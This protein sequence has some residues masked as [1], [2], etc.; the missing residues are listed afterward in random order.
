MD[1]LFTGRHIITLSE[2]PSTNTYAMQLLKEKDL[3]EGTL[4]MTGNQTGGRGQHGNSWEAERGKNLT[5]SL[6]MHPV[7]MTANEQFYLS[8]ITALAVLGTLTE[9]LPAS[10]YD[11]Q[12]KWP[13]DVLVQGEKIAGVLIENVVVGA[14]LQ[15]SVIGVGLNVNQER[16]GK[17]PRAATS[18]KKLLQ[19]DVEL[20]FVL[21]RFCKHFEALY[22]SLRQ[23][24]NALI[25]K[26]YISN[27]YR[28]NQRALYRAAGKEFAA[29]ICGVSKE[30]FLQVKDEGFQVLEFNFKEIEFL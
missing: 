15:T 5:F 17:M 2:V 16:F 11:I 24:R 4:V 29:T 8:K 26:Q 30:G 1:T 6:V 10:Q 3:T 27:L 20:R 22:L 18:L 28:C 23:G 19:K 12:I 14:H 13:N 21:E 9:F 25:D 7:F